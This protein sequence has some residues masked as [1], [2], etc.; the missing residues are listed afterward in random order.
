MSQRLPEYCPNEIVN[1]MSVGIKELYGCK[2]S[3]MKMNKHTS[4]N[5]LKI[6]KGDKMKYFCLLC[7]L[8]HRY[9][10]SQFYF[11]PDSIVNAPNKTCSH[12]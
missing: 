12:T 5:L 7:V 9:I 8:I 6:N 1:Y 3:G 11:S 4:Y 2:I 10:I